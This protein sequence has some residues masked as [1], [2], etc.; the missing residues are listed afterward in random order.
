VLTVESSPDPTVGFG[1]FVEFL[2]ESAPGGFGGVG[3]CVALV[4]G[5]EFVVELGEK[6][7]EWWKGEGEG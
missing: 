6:I 3:G 5:E 7:S 1:D 2:A 4:G